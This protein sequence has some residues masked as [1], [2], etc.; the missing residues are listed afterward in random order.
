MSLQPKVNSLTMNVNDLQNKRKTLVQDYRNELGLEKSTKN[1]VSNM[2]LGI[3][4]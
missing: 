4:E 1:K 3:A 2:H